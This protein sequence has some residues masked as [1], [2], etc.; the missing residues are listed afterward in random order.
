M[1][2]SVTI[3]KLHERV[4]GKFLGGVGVL[5]ATNEKEDVKKF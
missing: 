3:R 1:R 2:T 4:D 5:E